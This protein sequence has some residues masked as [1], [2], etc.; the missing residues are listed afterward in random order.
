M[1]FVGPGCG[2]TRSSWTYRTPPSLHLCLFH[3]AI[4][5][6]QT[7]QIE[8]IIKGYNNLLFHRCL[9]WTGV[10]RWVASDGTPWAGQGAVSILAS[11]CCDYSPPNVFKMLLKGL[12]LTKKK[13]NIHKRV[14]SSG[15]VKTIWILF[16]V[17]KWTL[18]NLPKLQACVKNS[19]SPMKVT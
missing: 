3:R 17:P 15:K 9:G 6:S 14:T 4:V 8:N 7:R 5:S 2:D 13:D 16:L 19:S 18:K 1:L 11:W 12:N 10:R